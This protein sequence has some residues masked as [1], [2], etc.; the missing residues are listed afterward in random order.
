MLAVAVALRSPRFEKMPSTRYFVTISRCT[1]VHELEVVRTE[2]ARDPHVR[3]GPVTAR[4][5]VGVDGDPVGMGRLHLVA[6]GVR[7]RSRDD[8]HAERAAAGEQ[9]PERIAVAQPRA[10]MV[11]RNLCR[12]VRDDAAGAQRRG[13]CVQ[14]A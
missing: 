2:R 3:V 1:S 11:Q 7:I 6:G 8:A 13:V 4:L 10:A 9:R 5:A 12:V 14:R